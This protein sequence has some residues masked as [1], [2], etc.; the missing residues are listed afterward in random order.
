[1]FSG[2]GSKIY[3][4]E[5]GKR[6]VALDQ[7]DRDYS[8]QALIKKYEDGSPIVLVADDTYKGF[9]Y[10]LGKYTYVILGY[11][12]IINVWGKIRHSILQCAHC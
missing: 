3:N 1:M 4:D 6:V 10:D 8:V 9:P 2:G 11:Y 12:R 7:D 5:S